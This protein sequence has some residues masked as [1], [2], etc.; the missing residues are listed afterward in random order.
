MFLPLSL[1][2]SKFTLI[3]NLTEKTGATECKYVI[4]SIC[5]TERTYSYLGMT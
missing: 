5:K 2:V 1:V 3:L 4:L